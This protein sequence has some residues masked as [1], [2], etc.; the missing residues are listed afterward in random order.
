MKKI[1]RSNCINWWIKKPDICEHC[2]DKAEYIIRIFSFWRGI[3]VAGLCEKC[4]N[5]W[6][7]DKIQI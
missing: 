7:D 1:G 5:L 3:R 4:R 2:G 6:I